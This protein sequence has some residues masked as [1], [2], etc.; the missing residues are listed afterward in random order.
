MKKILT[1]LALAASV[2]LGYSQGTVVFGSLSAVNHISTNS[3]LPPG[4][5]GVVGL[6]STAPNGYYYALLTAAYGGAAPTAGFNGWTFSGDYA[7]NSTLAPGATVV[8]TVAVSGWTPGTT[9]Y[10]EVLGWSASLGSDFLTVENEYNTGNWAPGGGSIGWS[11]VGFVTS[12]GV[13]SGGLTSPGTQLFGGNGITGFVLYT[14]PE[15]TT[16]ALIGIEKAK[17][18]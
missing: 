3:F 17:E 10:V 7:T 4:V 6:T 9:D 12:G 1:I 2:T 18:K 8:N 11:N 15:P 16:M 13:V 14:V 5:G